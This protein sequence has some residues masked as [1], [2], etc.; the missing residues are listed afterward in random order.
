MDIARLL[1]AECL[2]GAIIPVGSIAD[3][4]ARGDGGAAARENKSLYQPA[5][6][7][8]ESINWPVGI[9]SRNR[10]IVAWIRLH[11]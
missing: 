7:S 3:W 10:R 8:S 1:P 5:N 4:Y 9:R 6:R 2:Q 11:P